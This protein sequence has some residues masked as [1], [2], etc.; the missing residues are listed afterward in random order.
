MI[1]E[2]KQ[3][4]VTV[5]VR[6]R[7]FNENEGGKRCISVNSTKNSLNFLTSTETKEFTFD[8]VADDSICQVIK[9]KIFI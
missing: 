4:N 9:K 7:P 1:E 5:S 2:E 6:V 3:G 8:Y